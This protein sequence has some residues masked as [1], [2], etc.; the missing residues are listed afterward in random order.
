MPGEHIV[1]GLG[2]LGDIRHA[3]HAV[4]NGRAVALA[5][6]ALRAVTSTAARQAVLP[7]HLLAASSHAAAGRALLAGPVAT[8]TGHASRCVIAPAAT[9]H[10]ATGHDTTIC[11]AARE[12]AAAAHA[13]T[14]LHES[15]GGLRVEVPVVVEEGG[16]H[17][18]G[19]QV[20]ADP[21]GSILAG[22]LLEA[23]GLKVSAVPAEEAGEVEHISFPVQVQS[24]AGVA[25][26]QGGL[27]LQLLLQ[28]GAGVRLR[29]QVGTRHRRAVDCGVDARL[30]KLAPDAAVL[31]LIQGDI[32]AAQ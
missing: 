10:A 23:R 5:P 2:H 31:Q 19:C 26:P 24:F 15:G 21:V 14:T 22:K 4:I 25:Q 28:H 6:V 16:T 13:V 3:V 1:P 8:A 18:I 12:A 7:V 11:T 30:G 32:R 20:F 29:A 9:S 17:V 27:L